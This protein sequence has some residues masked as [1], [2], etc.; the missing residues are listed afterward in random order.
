MKLTD[1]NIESIKQEWNALGSTY[2]TDVNTMVKFGDTYGWENWKGEEP[3]D[4]R[5]HLSDAVY[6]LL[7]AANTNQTV[8]QFRNDFPPAHT[9]FIK[10]MQ[11]HGQSIEHARTVLK[12]ASS[13]SGTGDCHASQYDGTTLLPPLAPPRDSVRCVCY[14]EG[15]RRRG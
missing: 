6:Q 13:W 5:N 1:K 14:F 10:F 11:D 8:D 15:K 2:A 3:K 7:K 12:G 4:E 9:P